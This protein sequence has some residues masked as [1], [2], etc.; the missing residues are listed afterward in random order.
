MHVQKPP[1][2]RGLPARARQRQTPR[3]HPV[4]VVH[5]VAVEVN[6]D[7]TPREGEVVEPEGPADADGVQFAGPGRE[8]FGQLVGHELRFGSIAVEGC[9]EIAVGNQIEPQPPPARGAV[10]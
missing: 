7:P 6:V 9:G 2:H 5:R 4:K 1:Q 3:Y 8:A 10:Q